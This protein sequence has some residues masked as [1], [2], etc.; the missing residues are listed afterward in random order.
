MGASQNR[1]W[2]WD[3]RRELAAV[4]LAA[5]EQ[6]DEEIAMIHGGLFERGPRMLAGL[7]VEGA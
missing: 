1:T 2:K 3:E 5:D 4:L 6:T 7:R